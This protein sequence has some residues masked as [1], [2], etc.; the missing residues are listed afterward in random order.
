MTSTASSRWN[1]CT[2]S[3]ARHQTFIAQPEVIDG[4]SDLLVELLGPAG[5][6]ARTATGVN[7]LPFGAAVQLDFDPST[8][9]AGFVDRPMNLER[10]STTRLRAE[11]LLRDHWPDLRLMDQDPVMMGHLGGP[12]DEAG[13]QA[14]LE[15]N[16]A[17][18]AS[19]GFGL[20]ILRD[21]ASGGARR[22]GLCPPSPDRRTRRGRDRIRV[23]PGFLGSG[24]RHRGSAEM[25]R[26]RVRR[27]YGSGRWSR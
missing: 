1:A 14:Y 23:S 22:A 4:A 8:H 26:H 2:A 5:R 10:F 20:W 25:R 6:H 17:H 3:Y 15:R 21:A 9:L 11:R 7:Q 18:W 19:Y 12:R 27:S 16:L 13:T 24:P